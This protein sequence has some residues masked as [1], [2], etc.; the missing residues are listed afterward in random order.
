[1]ALRLFK[2]EPQVELT[3]NTEDAA[4][5]KHVPAVTVDGDTV[6]VVVGDVEHPMLDAHYIQFIYLETD[7]GV[8]MKMLSPGEAPK[9]V[10][11]LDGAAPVAVYELCNL[12]GLWKKEL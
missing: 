12:H 11:E 4:V 10:F 9:A 1:M 8:Q 7:K 5:E 2:G 6:S 3:A